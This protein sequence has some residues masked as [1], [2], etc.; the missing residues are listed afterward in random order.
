[1]TAANRR[2]KTSGLTRDPPVT[3]DAGTSR[4]QEDRL[5]IR[6]RAGRIR[7]TTIR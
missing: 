4:V 7:A 2:S 6:R 3:I 5:L 1:M